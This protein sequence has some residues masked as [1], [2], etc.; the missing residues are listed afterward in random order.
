MD[1]FI[2]GWCKQRGLC[3]HF[4]SYYPV[5]QVGIFFL[6]LYNETKAAAAAAINIYTQSLS[7]SLSLLS[8][9]LK[10][11][12]LANRGTLAIV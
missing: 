5:V 10:R 6:V 8:F 1:Y 4:I 3:T 11:R 9:K 2:R 7:L 12:R